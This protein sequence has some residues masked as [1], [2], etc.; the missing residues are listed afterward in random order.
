MSRRAFTLVE[1][2]TVIALIGVLAALLLPAVQAARGAARNVDCKNKIHQLALAFQTHYAAHGRFAGDGWGY[3]WVGDPDRGDGWRQPGGWIYRLLPFIEADTIRQLGSDQQPDVITPEQEYGLAQATQQH[4]GWFN[5][6]SR[7]PARLT[8]LTTEWEYVNMDNGQL[9]AT[10]SYDANWGS[11]PVVY[12]GGPAN[13]IMDMSERQLNLL[14]TSD[15]IVFPLS[16][17]KASRITDGLSKTYLVGDM[18]FWAT[19]NTD[20]PDG[21][22]LHSPLSSYYVK[23]AYD[24][25]LRDMPPDPTIGRAL[26]R[27]GSAY[28]QNWNVAFC[29]GSVQSM[30]FDIELETHRRLANRADGVPAA[31]SQ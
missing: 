2:L 31:A 23:S 10:V 21:R 3:R 13:P 19:D 26:Q 5:C 9:T 7:R 27:W 20:S 24:P 22:E 16:A 11:Q 25:P 30:S 6:P 17:I 29:D 28:P 14:P 1:L 12:K 4:L 8:L 18:F 15:G